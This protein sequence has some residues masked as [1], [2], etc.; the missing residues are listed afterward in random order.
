[1]KTFVTLLAILLAMVFVVPAFA[2]EEP[3][4]ASVWEDNYIPNFYISPKEKQFTHCDTDYYDGCTEARAIDDP[5]G[6][7]PSSCEPWGTGYLCKSAC[8]EAF[9]Y[10]ASATV[11]QEVCCTDCTVNPDQPKCRDNEGLTAIPVTIQCPDTEKW[12]E[13]YG[14]NALITATNKGW[15]QWVIGLPKKPEGELNLEIECGV[16]K[17]NSWETQYP[18]LGYDVIN[19]CAG[20]TGEPIGSGICTRVA[21]A[22]LNEKALPRLEIIAYPGCNHP[23]GFAPFHLTAY[24]NPGDYKI[25]GSKLNN[26][27]SLQVLN[28]SSNSRIALKGCMEKTVIMKWPQAGTTNNMGEPEA[29]LEAGDLIVVR[30]SLLKDNTVDVYCNKYSAKI[31]GIGEAGTLL[32]D[33]DC[34]CLTYS[35]CELGQYPWNFIP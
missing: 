3:Y 2:G 19:L 24:K 33:E 20:V 9:K 8:Q 18:V 21:G 28:G 31:G 17:P 16:L 4:K 34:K 5:R 15:Y 10:Q 32:D 1:M 6:I 23:K 11:D 25:P 35:Q 30:L 7:D 26:N 14:G 27:R 22:P 29:N 13:E 12:W